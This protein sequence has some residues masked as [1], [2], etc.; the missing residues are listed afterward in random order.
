MG[1]APRRASPRAA[2]SRCI[3]TGKMEEMVAVAK[4]VPALTA[5][6]GGAAGAGDGD[7]LYARRRHRFRRCRREAGRAAGARLRPDLSTGVWPFH[8]ALPESSGSV[9][10]H[11]G[12]CARSL[13]RLGRADARTSTGGKV[14]STC[15]SAWRAAQK[16][17]LAQISILQLVDQ[18]TRLHRQRARAEARDRGRLSRD[19][20]VARLPEILPAAAQGPGSG[21]EPRG[22]RAA[23][24]D[25]A[26]AAR[27]DARGGR[28]AAGPRPHRPRRVRSRRSGRAAA[29][30]QGRVAGHA[31]ST[32]S[33]AY[34]AVKART[35][36]RDARRP[37]AL[38]DDARRSD[39][40]RRQ[41]DRNGD[42]LDG[43]R[44]LPARERRPGVSA[45][46][47]WRR[48]SSPRSSL[49][50]VGGSTSARTRRSRR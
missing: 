42:R 47:R 45:A 24:A 50:A 8:F 16:V 1:S 30:P 40:A 10:A 12:G 22:G 17:D 39:R 21:S 13:G 28:P 49:P 31:R 29:G 20:G 7:D 25:A 37:C 5:E 48:A 43:A 41:D 9:F 15:C 27:C 18:Y 44:S 6:G 34:G 35:A 46:R 32:C 23:A 36:A 33:P 26:S 4:A 2:T 3:A 11:G 14:R 38:G 19:G